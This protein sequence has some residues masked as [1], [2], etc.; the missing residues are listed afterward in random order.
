MARNKDIPL[1]RNPP[2]GDGHHVTY[3]PMTARELTEREARQKDHEAM[4]ARQDEYMRKRQIVAVEQKTVQ[5]GCVF[6]KS[7]KLPDAVINYSNPSG[8]V[9]TDSLEDYGEIAWLGAREADDGGLLNLQ[10]I[11]GSTLSLGVGRLALRAPAMQVMPAIGAAASATLAGLLAVFW[12][13]S[14]GDSA[15]YSED[16][17]RALKQA[18]TRVRLQIEQQADGSLKGYGFYTG[19]NRDWEMVDVVQIAMRGSQYIADLGD[20]IELIWTPA[21]DG[22]DILGI[23]KL[24]AAPQAPHIWVFPPTKQ[25]DAIIV[26]PI[27]PP[28]YKDF[29]LVFPVGT[30]VRPVYVV[31]SVSHKYHPK[32]N[33]LPAFP[34]AKWAPPKTRMKGGGL[35]PRWKDGS[36]TIYEWDFQHGAVEKYN[37]RG[38]HLGEFDHNSGIQTKP[39]DPTRSIEP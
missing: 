19:K 31:V 20:G 16:Q 23:P 26:N 27:Y 5:A 4:L 33:V 37:K 30:G 24:E 38:K 13:P 3:R 1:I 9:P 21:V 25:A 36:G 35:R 2:S 32:P 8:M 12:T 22:T 18:R 15:L 34:G 6:A 14:L 17:L 39:A 10:T 7:C 11:S 29:I 28:E